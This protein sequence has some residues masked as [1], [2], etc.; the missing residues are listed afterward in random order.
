MFRINTFEIRIPP[1]R[2]RTEDLPELV[3]HL[4][5]RLRFQVGVQQEVV[6]HEALDVLR[7]HDWPG[8]V[9]ELAN[10]IEYAT[11][12]CEQPPIRPDHLPQRF[13]S[14]QPRHGSIKMTGPMTLREIEDAGDLCGNRAKRGQQTQSRGRTGREPQDALQQTESGRREREQG[15]IAAT[16]Y[17][18]PRNDISAA[19]SADLAGFPRNYA[20]LRL[21]VI[22][23]AAYGI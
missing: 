16:A 10:V 15:G 5:G 23:M 20:H 4:L 2:E 19:D 13:D 9:R 3:R 22:C 12:L 11:I 21:V 1:L 18:L 8:N 14:P 17:A 7:S 6:S